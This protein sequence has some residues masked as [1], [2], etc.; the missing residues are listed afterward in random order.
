MIAELGHYFLLLALVVSLIGS[1]PLFRPA[2]LNKVEWQRIALLSG[3]VLFALIFASFVALVVCFICDDFSVSLVYQNSH[4]LQP[5]LYKVAGT[6]GNH[7]G[8]LLLWLLVLSICAAANRMPRA[9]VILSALA[10]VFLLL[11][12]FTSNPF[13]RL[14]PA[15]LD[16]QDLNPLL[17]DPGLAFHPPLLYIG[18]VGYALVFATAVAALWEGSLA[19]YLKTLRFWALLAWSFLTVGLALGSWWAYYELG[20]GGWWFWDPVENAALIPWLVG[21]ALLHSVRVAEAKG[22]L[23]RWTILLAIITFSLSLLGTF[24]VR[25][26]VLTS[27]HAF[28]SDPLRGLA[29]LVVFAVTVGGAFTL[30]SVR[31]QQM[32]PVQ[33]VPPLSREGMLLLN[34]VFL[35]VAAA[36]VLIGTLYPLVVEAL[37]L[38]PITVGPPYF[39]ATFVPMMLPLLIVV[40]FGQILPWGA[41]QNITRAILPVIIAMVAVAMAWI[42]V[43]G[44]QNPLPLLGFVFGAGVVLATIMQWRRARFGQLL[45]HIGLGIAVM[46]MAGSALGP[47][48]IIQLQQGDKVEFAGYQFDF[49]RAYRN[50]GPNFLAEGAVFDVRAE[51]DY[52]T[53]M[54]AERRYYPVADQWTTEAAIHTTITGDIFI[55][56]GAFKDGAASVRFRF[57]P[58]QAWIWCGALL[59]LAGGLSAAWRS[60]R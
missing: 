10:F 8:S 45:A 60:R 42:A 21:A 20:W 50:A 55:A 7:E 24:L 3:R 1:M 59:M 28:A 15:P 32:E 12:V 58:L 49:E 48:K 16:G 14:S 2:L 9:A 46:G 17:Q 44:H 33:A 57:V 54:A 19:P 22:A 41:S 13:E 27:V 36:T 25:S 39:N 53:R 30:L 34:N 37:G 38:A 35:S 47:E 40:A 31:W 29:L 43:L 4:T 56:I 51:G 5:L 26:G 18:Y 52:V 6:W 11:S 23:Q